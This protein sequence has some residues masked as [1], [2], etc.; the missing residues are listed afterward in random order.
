MIFLSHNHNDKP[1]VE[2]VAIR[3]GQIFGQD[4]VFYDSWSMQP[5]DGI[6]QK[7][8]EGMKSPRFVF[9]FVSANSLASKMVELEWQNALYKSTKGECKIIPVRVDGSPMPPILLQ[10]LYIDM[11]SHGIEAAIVQIV[12]V[13][14]G[15][16]TFTPQHLGFSN[17]TFHVTG[18]PAKELTIRISASHLMEP[19][20]DFLVLVQNPQNEVTIELNGGQPHRGGFNANLT[21]DNGTVTNAYAI[22]PL[23]GA[24]TPQMPMIVT[25]KPQGPASVVLRGVFHRKNHEKYEAIPAGPS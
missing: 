10:N 1:V 21:L 12:N 15:N 14:Q 7:M 24:I 20:P 9:F 22:A 18:D 16:N 25:L 17:L 13:I 8:N 5:G 11:Y 23:G 3:L 2:P 4:K 6:I 19:N